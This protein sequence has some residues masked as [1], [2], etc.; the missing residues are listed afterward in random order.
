LKIQTLCLEEKNFG[1]V[2]TPS[3]GLGNT[4]IK[5]LKKIGVGFDEII[6]G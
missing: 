3:I 2:V 5:R 4:L 6:P 1:G